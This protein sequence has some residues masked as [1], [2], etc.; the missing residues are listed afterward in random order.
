MVAS[1][2]TWRP[3]CPSTDRFGGWSHDCWVYPLISLKVEVDDSVVK[4]DIS[5]SLGLVVTEL[6]INSLKHALPGQ[7]P[8]RIAVNYRS[9]GAT[10]MLSVAD[11]GVGIPGN[12][13]NSKAGLGTSIVRAL[14]AQ[15]EAEIIIADDRPGTHVSLTHAPAVASSSAA[16]TSY[17][18]PV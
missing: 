13:G 12:L 10:W 4:A 18:A 3:I 1:I 6:V 2:S 16:G 14:A 9:R 8:G 11:D 15:L 5:I 7:R 17:I